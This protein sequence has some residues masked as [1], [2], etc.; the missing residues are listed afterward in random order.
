MRRLWFVFSLGPLALP[1]DD[2]FAPDKVQHFFSSAFVQSMSYGA[3]RT[4]GV[5][6]GV[7]LAGASVTSAAVGVGKEVH[8]LRTHG[9][10]SVRD[11]TWDA[12]GAGAAS[13]LLVRTQR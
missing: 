4:T 11:L 2:W 3:L 10:F 5:S 7:A 9:E 8:D 12:I 13:V 1:G 6:H